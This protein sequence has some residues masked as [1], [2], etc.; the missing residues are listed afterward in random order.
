M[1]WEQVRGHQ[2]QVE[3]LRRAL[4]RG[5]LPHAM[6]F[7]GADGI[8]KR[9]VARKL[10]QSLFCQRHADVELQMCGECSGCKSFQAASHPDYFEIGLRA[11]QEPPDARSVS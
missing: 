6:L 8:G 3:M 9:L 4:S 2:A 7:V 10:A 11:R 1:G 5:R